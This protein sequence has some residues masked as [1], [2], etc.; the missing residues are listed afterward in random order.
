MFWLTLFIVEVYEKLNIARITTWN[1]IILDSERLEALGYNPNT[2][3][4]W[5]SQATA[6]TDC[7]LYYKQAAE[8]IIISDIDDILFPKLGTDYL[9]EFRRLSNSLPYASSFNYN[10]YNTEVVSSKHISSDTFKC[11]F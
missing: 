3:L 7:F 11:R 6:H 10:R 1:Q 5:R 4:E 8:F 9:S 2:E